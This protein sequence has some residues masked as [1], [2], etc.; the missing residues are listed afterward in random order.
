MKRI[1]M[2]IVGA[3]FVGPH[4]IDAVRRLGYVDVVA[5]AGS[6]EASAEKKADALGARKAY[7][8]YEALLDD[9]DVQVVHN[10]TPNYLHYP[11]NAAAIAKGK[12][13]VSDKPLAMTAAE[14]QDA[15]RSGDEGRHRPRRH[16]QLSR[17]SARA[18]GA[19]MRSRAATSAR[20]TFVHR[21]LPAGL[22]A[23]GHRLLVAARA[24]QGRRLVGAR[25][26]RLA[27][28]RS[29]AAHQRPAHHPRARRH[30]DRHP[31]A[32]EAEGLARGVRRRRRRRG[33]ERVD[34]KVED[35]ASVLL[36]FDNGAKGS[37]S[38]GQV[39]AGHKNDLHARGLRLEARRCAG[40]RS[41]RTSCGSATATSANEML[42]KDPSL[43]DAEAA[44]LRASAGRP[45]GGVGGRVLQPDARHLRLHRRG[46]E[47]VA[48]RIRRRS[49]RSRTATAP[50]A[51]SRRF[52]RAR[53]RRRRLDEGRHVLN[54][55]TIKPFEPK[56]MKV[57][58]LTA[59]L[60]ELTPREV[61]DADPDRAIEDWLEFAQRAR[62]RLHPA[63]GGAASDA[64]RDVPPE[65]MLD[66][67]ANTLDLRQPFDKDRARARRR[68]RSTPTRRRHL[69]HRL[70]RQHAAPRPG[71]PREEARLHA[72]RVR[73]RGAARRRRGLRLRRPQPAAQHGPEPRRLRGAVRAA[74][75]GGEGARPDLPRRAVPDARLDDRRQLAQQHRLHARHL[76]RAAP[77]LREARRRR[78]VPHPLR[79]VARDPDGAGHAVDLPVPE[80]HRLQ[81]PDRRL[82]REG[83]GHRR[84]GRVGVGLRRPDASSAATGST[85]SRRRTR[86]IS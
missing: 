51:S 59:A 72:A 3:G 8:S 86:P 2:G 58:V 66:P 42:Q 1:G 18:A 14:A 62:R 54:D 53:A 71:D 57:G 63:V 70:L 34:I 32:Q 82:P 55:M 48:T 85:A 50:T 19:R 28:V 43:L 61:R 11:V 24:G 36:R 73:R 47:A 33:V 9:P 74:A 68:R 23:Q 60:Q 38:V 65:A 12:H 52:S 77:H 64:R 26:H 78:S 21:P 81:L 40:G 35:L 16:V 44:R 29:G 6:S 20:R 39:C 69:G 10:A 31:E 4:H 41:T 15:A 22:A 84:E 5:V 80:G 49:R 30:H 45:P 25:R 27:L 37:F 83:A 76:D 13:V 56:F 79:S 17:Q 46:Q 75:Q 67:V 7:G